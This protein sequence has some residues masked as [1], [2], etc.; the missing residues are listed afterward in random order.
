MHVE[1][2][3]WRLNQSLM[4]NGH[5]QSHPSSGAS[6]NSQKGEDLES[7]QI[8]EHMEILGEEPTQREQGSYLSFPSNTLCIFSTWLCLN[9][10]LYLINGLT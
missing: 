8:G 9:S 4:A 5:N 2:R 6:I 10:I 3:H 1:E 7:F